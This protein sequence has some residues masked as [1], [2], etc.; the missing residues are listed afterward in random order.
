MILR[1]I[2][3]AVRTQNWF[4]VALEVLIVVVGIFIGLQADAWNQARQD[5]KAEE[6]FVSQLHEDIQRAEE[7]SQRVR[8]RRIENLQFAIA[9]GDVLFDRTERDELSNDECNA[10]GAIGAFNIA[11][12]DLPSFDELMA[13]GRLHILQDQELRN[14]L[15]GFEQAKKNLDGLILLQ[16]LSSPDLLGTY[17]SMVQRDSYFDPA[18]NEIRGKHKCDVGRMRS[19]RAFLNDFSEAIDIYD[20]YVRDG[21]MP[22]NDHL[23]SLHVI[24]DSNMGIDHSASQ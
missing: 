19:N 13:T 20:G 1:R 2:A 23:V 9:A 24:V 17:P 14:A 21:L 10:I 11:I 16:T 5:R 22:W 7:F 6:S 12:V 8:N 15:L 18:D 4:T 3:D